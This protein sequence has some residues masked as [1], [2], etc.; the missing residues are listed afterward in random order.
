MHDLSARARTFGSLGYARGNVLLLQNTCPAL[1]VLLMLAQLYF[2]RSFCSRPLAQQA[3]QSSRR[4]FAR[5]PKAALQMV[6]HAL[7]EVV[8]TKGVPVSS[9]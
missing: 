7:P 2:S 8:E 1:T 6:E 3:L 5:R 9:F 4:C